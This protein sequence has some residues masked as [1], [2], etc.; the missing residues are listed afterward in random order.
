MWIHKST[1]ENQIYNT[2][3]KSARVPDTEKG[4]YG[5][6]MLRIRK[7]TVNTSNRT[8]YRNVCSNLQ[9]MWI[10][11]PTSENQIYNTK[12]KSARV[13]DTEKRYYR[14]R[15]LRIR[16][17]TVNTSN[18]TGVNSIPEVPTETNR[19]NSKSDSTQQS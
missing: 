9:Y 5:I 11:K 3:Q 7:T 12:Q 1:S 18:R 15:M 10:H 13:P 19:C 16:K 17:T 6:R 14:I 2:K 8:I 4:Y